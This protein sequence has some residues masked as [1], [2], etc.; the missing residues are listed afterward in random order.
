MVKNRIPVLDQEKIR[1]ILQNSGMSRTKLGELLGV[2]YQ[3][4]YRW[5][6]KG[7]KPRRKES[8]EIDELFKATVDLRPTVLKLKET[9]PDPLTIIRQNRKFYD[10]L[11]LR[12][13]FHTNAI[14]GSRLTLQETQRILDGKVVE[15]RELFELLEA[16]NHKNAVH[17]LFQVIHPGF[18][19]DE[20]FL[21]RLHGIVMYDFKNKLPGQYRTGSIN[22]ANTEKIVPNAQM[23][24]IRMKQF[25][26][27][28]N[29]L[30]SDP[31]GKIARDHFEFESIHP[32][33]DGNGRL[34]RLLMAT[35]L[36]C[37]GFPPALIEIEDQMK[38]YTAFD[39]ADNGDVGY[40]TQLVAEC[41]VKGFEFFY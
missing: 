11:T 16:V 27:N 15:G 10:D 26:K 6:D 14:E 17:H 12:L 7:T 20:A 2:N 23:V 40:M 39:K 3:T 4:V 19:I 36:L 35:Q 21:L 33:F 8:Q 24:P 34:G 32:F 37:N 18:K 31:I 30:T 5:A 9:G 25:L 13:T 29:D 41:V 1:L 28:V 22:V 38:Y